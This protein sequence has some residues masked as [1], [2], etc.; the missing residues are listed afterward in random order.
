MVIVMAENVRLDADPA[1]ELRVQISV[2]GDVPDVQD[3]QGPAVAGLEV[4]Q[5]FEKGREIG[6]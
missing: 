4:R 1:Q 6:V 2:R 5:P 3:P